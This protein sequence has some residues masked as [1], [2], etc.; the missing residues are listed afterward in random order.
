MT[1]LRDD[2]V[3]AMP[4]LAS[5]HGAPAIG[6][7]I[8]TSIWNRE[9][10]GRLVPTR[11]NDSPAFLAYG[12]SD[13]GAGFEAVA[14]LVL[15]VDQERIARIDAFGDPGLFAAFGATATLAS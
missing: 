10:P 9:R 11:A 4:P 12:S 13:T 15:D 3:L 7:F 5:V 14:I 2:A 8:A 1:L 6:Q